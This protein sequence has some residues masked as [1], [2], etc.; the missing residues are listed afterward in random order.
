MAI[1]R[2]RYYFWLARAYITRLRKTII[3]SL[4]AG[5]IVFFILATFF[6]FYLLPKI[7]KKVQR[8]GYFGVY[9]TQNLPK[10]VL[11]DVSYGLTRVSNDTTVSPGASFTWQVKDNGKDYIFRIRK[12]QFFGNGRELTAKNLNLNFADVKKKI[13]DEY[14]VEYILKEP[15]SPFL[16]SAAKP[17]LDKNFSGLGEFKV[18]KVDLNGGFI[19]SLTLSDKKSPTEKKEIYFYP[20]SEALK[21]A[22]ALGQIDKAVGVQDKKIA[23]KNFSEWKNTDIQKNVDYATLVTVFYNNADSTL[24]DKKLR[25]ALSYAIPAEFSEGERAYSPIAPISIYFSRT[26]NY[27]I[28]NI[29]VSKSLLSGNTDINKK[30][31]EISVPDEH[32][33]VAEKVAKE[34]SKIGVKTKIKTVNSVPSNFQI[35]I[36]PIKL[37]QDPDQYTLW[38]SA[39]VDNIVKYKNLRIDKLLEDGRST[40]DQESRQNIYTDF[41]KYLIDDAP[42]G[43]LYFPYTYTI[44]RK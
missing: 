41:Q 40:S 23:D 7:Q 43:F 19:R 29:D 28:S 44:S 33:S 25:Q 3:S 37:P 4:V 18:S 9:N 30:T 15:Y 39:Q 27:G 22:Y 2:R 42:A 17:I 13:L 1:V 31:F 24:S 12:G 20:T 11:D 16:V 5:I 14:T 32:K 36:Y 34:W 35:L 6:N 26:P 8:I 21:T 38:H 10:E